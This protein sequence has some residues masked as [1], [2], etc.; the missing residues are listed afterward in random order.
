MS[1]F[2][3]LPAAITASFLA[4]SFSAFAAGKS[5]PAP[6]P[7]GEFVEADF[8]FFSSV[9]DARKLGDG[10][11]AD[12]LTPRALVLNLGQDC[13]AAFDTELLRVAA[14]WTGQGVSPASMAQGSYHVSGVKASEGQSK[15][16][17]IV[18]SPWLASGAYPA[19][20]SGETLSF[21]DPRE[22]GPDAKEIGRGPLPESLGRFKAVR[23]I[24]G[25]A[26][27]EYTVRD[28]AVTDM[29]EAELRGICP[30]CG[31]ICGWGRQ[32]GPC[33]SCSGKPRPR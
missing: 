5:K 13:W 12:N 8:P 2:L 15:L 31:V 33:A 29:F 17:R 18:G 21:A 24:E 32:R 11:P 6:S 23:L 10:L 27:L 30:L 26:Q 19:W 20:Q 7:W 22:A 28:S 3:S 9:V 1:S 14:I 4:L 16:P 25:G